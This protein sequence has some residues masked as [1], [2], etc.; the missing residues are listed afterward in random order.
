MHCSAS[1]GYV[2]SKIK[3][4]MFCS[5][6]YVDCKYVKCHSRKSAPKSVHAYVTELLKSV[7][8]SVQVEKGGAC[9]TVFQRGA[10]RGAGHMRL[11]LY[12]REKKSSLHCLPRLPPQLVAPIFFPPSALTRV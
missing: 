12:C 9:V 5:R 8:Q 2:I 11:L 10:E 7:S 1:G 6:M 3:G 4:K